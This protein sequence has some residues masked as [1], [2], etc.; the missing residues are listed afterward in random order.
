MITI[1]IFNNAS[2]AVDFSKHLQREEGPMSGYD[3][4]DY[5]VFAISQ[6][7][8]STLYNRKK[9]DAYKMFYEKYYLK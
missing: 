7:N 9:V 6:Q 1:K 8:Y 3:M 4:N 2:D 5:Q